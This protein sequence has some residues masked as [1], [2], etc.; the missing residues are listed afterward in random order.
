MGRRLAFLLALAAAAPSACATVAP[1]RA[2]LQPERLAEAAAIAE[3]EM[4]RQG[5]PGMA[6]VVMQG[7]SVALARGFGLESAERPDP[8]TP[9]SLFMYNSLSKQ[10]VAAAVMRLEEAGRLSID[11]SVSRHLPDWRHVPPALR[12]R[13]LLNHSSG[14]RDVNVQP[15][16]GALFDRPGTSW[17]DFASA[18]RDTPADWA[19][20][21]R[22]SYA[23]V[24][25]LMLQLVVERT[26]GRPLEAALSDLLFRPLGLGSVRLCPSPPGERRGEA[27]GHVLRGG[28]LAGHDPEPAHLFAGAGGFCGT[29]LDL[30]RWTRAL[31]SG[32]VVSRASFERMS[33]PARLADGS[34]ADY[35]FAFSLVRPD[36]VRRIG[37]GGY[38]GGYSAQAAHYPDSDLTTVVIGNRFLQPESIER[39]LVR[40]LL[41]L[42]APSH[43]EVALAAEQRRAFAGRFD[44][45]VHGWHPRVEE[46]D[47]RL[48]FVLPG[49][50]IA[51]PLTYVGDHTLAAADDADG[52]RLRF[53]PDR[54]RLRLLGMGLMTWYGVRVP[55]AEAPGL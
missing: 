46:R 12:I 5:M 4:R 34:S 17:S 50:P 44:V 1:S 49:P 16:L 3:A 38:G 23:N 26:T 48:W 32:R 14:M 8:A 19:P 6:L 13:H 52:Y 45:G 29:A 28:T 27:R 10:F 9:D 11:D 35:G 15:S 36:G 37:H 22:W 21:A 47:G 53:S 18:A 30:A 55:E 31:V 25:Y 33:A 54:S 42:P 20:G 39:K 7:E 2:A 43:T 51:F 24:N 41:G 40:H